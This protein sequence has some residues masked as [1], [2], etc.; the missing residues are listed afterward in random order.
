MV[1]CGGWLIV[2][3]LARWCLG[4]VGLDVRIALVGEEEVEYVCSVVSFDSTYVVL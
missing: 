3:Y 1:T 2:V 4:W